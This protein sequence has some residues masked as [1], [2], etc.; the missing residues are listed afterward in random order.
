MLGI[1]TS[2]LVENPTTFPKTSLPTVSDYIDAFEP[3]AKKGDRHSMHL[4]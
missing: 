1:S 4:H 2:F 3:L